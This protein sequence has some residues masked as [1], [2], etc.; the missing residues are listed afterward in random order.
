MRNDEKLQFHLLDGNGRPCGVFD[1]AIQEFIK[2]KHKL[3]ILAGTPYFY[4]NGAYK[5]DKSGT[6]L[7]ATDISL[8]ERRI[9]YRGRR[10]CCPFFIRQWKEGI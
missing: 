5:I 6:R 2:E 10:Y 4:E 9:N 8:F 3:F 7:K 1:Y